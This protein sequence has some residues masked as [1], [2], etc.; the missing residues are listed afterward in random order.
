MRAENG[1]NKHI[2]TTRTVIRRGREITV[3]QLR[4]DPDAPDYSDRRRKLGESL[5][6]IFKKY[7]GGKL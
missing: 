7:G 3:E 5:Y 6:E 4:P 1:N 2:I